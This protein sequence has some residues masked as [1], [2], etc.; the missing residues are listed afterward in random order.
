MPL[1]SYG[2]LRRHYRKVLHDKKGRR[3]S[4]EISMSTL[5]KKKI[6]ITADALSR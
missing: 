6:Y 4:D 5:L 3:V 2:F 1:D